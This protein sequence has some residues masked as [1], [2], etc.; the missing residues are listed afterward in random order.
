MC[1]TEEQIRE[2]LRDLPEAPTGFMTFAEPGDFH[3][4]IEWTVKRGKMMSFRLLDH[5]N[6]EIF[7]TQFSKGTE[8]A[9]HSHGT[10]SEEIIVV[11]EGSMLV[12]LENGDR[13][14]LEEKDKLI[15]PKGI[16]HMAVIG[17]KPCQIIA[18]TIPKERHE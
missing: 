17:D 8:I 13:I 4:I 6:C 5:T 10:E 2:R 1:V 7:H 12:I 11:L 16:Q 3:G 9:W 15:I 14:K 18:M